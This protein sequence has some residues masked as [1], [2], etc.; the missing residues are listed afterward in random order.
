MS[1]TSPG[2]DLEIRFQ[3]LVTLPQRSLDQLSSLQQTYGFHFAG[4]FW[5]NSL[6]QNEKWFLDQSGQ[7]YVITPDGMIQSATYQ[8][9]FLDL[10]G[11]TYVLT[12]GHLQAVA[13]QMLAQGI[14]WNQP[15]TVTGRYSLVAVATVDPT[16]WDDLNL[17]FQA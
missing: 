8:T 2:V 5:Q 14:L 12:S 16:V 1:S 10:S 9:Y 6:G 4:S 11:Q 3:A 7:W 13:D 17:L 15:L